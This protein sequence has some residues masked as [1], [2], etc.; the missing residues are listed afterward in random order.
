M[1]LRRTGDAL[2]ANQLSNQMPIQY[3]Q[4]ITVSAKDYTHEWKRAFSKITAPLSL[5]LQARMQS[6]QLVWSGL[7][8]KRREVRYFFFLQ[9]RTPMWMLAH[10]PQPTARVCV[11]ACLTNR[12]DLY[13]SS[14]MKVAHPAT[15]CVHA[16]H[17]TTNYT[18]LS[19]HVQI[20]LIRS[21][22]ILTWAS[23]VCARVSLLCVCA[24]TCNALIHYL[25]HVTEPQICYRG[26][27]IS[28]LTLNKRYLALQHLPSEGSDAYLFIYFCFVRL[29]SVLFP[30]TC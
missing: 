24:R 8:K 13:A 20:T 18:E 10:S 3:T 9:W 1:R 11:C 27:K 14:L 25:I 22:W 16:H 23:A 30:L 15:M 2:Q 28:G 19:C 7:W 26:K 6:Y 29:F 5:D 4:P 21:S 12:T 17:A